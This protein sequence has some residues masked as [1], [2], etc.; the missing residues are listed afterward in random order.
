[1]KWFVILSVVTIGLALGLPPDPH[2]VQS[3]HT[4][5]LAYRV[6]VAALLIPYAIIWYLSFYAY[7]KLQEY[8]KPLKKAKDGAAFHTITN[9]IGVLAFALV[10]PTTISLI[11]GNIAG[12]SPGFK[13]AST[14]IDN[15]ISIIPGLFAFFLLMNGTRLLIRTVRGATEKIDLRWHAPWFLLLSVVFS[16]LT[17]QNQYHSHPYH[18][19]LWLLVVT[20]IIPYLYG[21]MVGLLSA[22]YLHVYSK[23][24]SGVLYRN[25]VKQLANGITI[26]IIGS[27]AIQFVNITVGQRVHSLGI[28]LLFDYILLILV[29]VGLAFMALG[30]KKLKRIEEI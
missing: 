13:T 21:W 14:I 23:T 3:L 29:A 4:S 18:L 1:M 11:I 6:A 9:G 24:V 7:A 27:I 15:Y 16:H 5:A 30:T 12:H 25:S 28:V 20:F 17:I 10:L 2:S 19:V 26:T 8:T 22:Y